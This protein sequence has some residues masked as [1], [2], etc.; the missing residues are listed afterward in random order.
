MLFRSLLKLWNF[1]NDPKLGALSNYVFQNPKVLE[2]KN[3][4]NFY[5]VAYLIGLLLS[6]FLMIRVKVNWLKTTLWLITICFVIPAFD[7]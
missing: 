3:L 5:L 7:S 2:A 6:I 1:W 4:K